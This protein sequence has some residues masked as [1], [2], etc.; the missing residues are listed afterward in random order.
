MWIAVLPKPV[1]FFF[2]SADKISGNVIILF[3]KYEDFFYLF[4]LLYSSYFSARPSE[5]GN[6]SH[7]Q[8]APRGDKLQLGARGLPRLHHLSTPKSTS[9]H[10]SKSYMYSS[11]IHVACMLHTCCNI[12]TE[13][14]VTTLIKD[15]N[16]WTGDIQSPARNKYPISWSISV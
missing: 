6:H 16:F 5:E 14:Y 8:S 13:S 10:T 12:Q 2:R 1:C 15:S 9:K 11:C 3:M 4:L 7:V